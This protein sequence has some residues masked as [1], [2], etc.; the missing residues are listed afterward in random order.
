[1][2]D[3]EKPNK[4]DVCTALLE[5]PWVFVHL[6]P[7]REGVLVPEWFKNQAQ[8]VLQLGLNMAIPIPDLE[9]GDDAITC[10]LSFSRQRHYCRLPW[11]AIYAL[12]GDDARGMV[13]S[14]DVPPEVAAQSRAQKQKLT[15]AEA[16][17]PKVAARLVPRSDTPTASSATAPAKPV[18]VPRVA[19]STP[20]AP[21]L[22]KKSEPKPKKARAGKAK[23][24]PPTKISPAKRDEVDDI[25]E[26]I[27][28]TPGKKPKRELP[29]YL[30]VIK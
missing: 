17:K 19:A 16:P 27:A 13:W 2:S 9:I 10:T 18:A 3:G 5:G 11:T 30:R 28:Q 20:P 4:K 7:R 8:L 15:V 21:A 14:E 6:D 12:L 29:S 23:I 1:M 26:E 22:A 25:A 24:E